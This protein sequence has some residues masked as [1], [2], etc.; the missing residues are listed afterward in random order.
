MLEERRH[1]HARIERRH[2][3]IEVELVHQ[4]HVGAAAIGGGAAGKRIGDAA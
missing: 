2:Y 1:G 4:R 3:R